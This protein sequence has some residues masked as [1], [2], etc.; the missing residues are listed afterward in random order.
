VY[1]NRLWEQ[2]AKSR[3]H[4]AFTL[5]PLLIKTMTNLEAWKTQRIRD[6][7]I[8]RYLD[9]GKDFVPHDVID[10]KIRDAKAPDW[11]ALRAILDKSLAIKDLT[12]DEVA[13]LVRVEDPEMLS[14]MRE[15]ALKVKLKV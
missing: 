6:D 8:R 15:T 7:E 3:E 4:R 2:I 11:N 5:C 14:A 12:P 10:Q 9:N 1:L 13:T